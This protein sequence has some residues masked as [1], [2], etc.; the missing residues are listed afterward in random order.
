MKKASHMEQLNRITLLESI[1]RS[2]QRL[3]DSLSTE[4]KE[5]FIQRVR[6]ERRKKKGVKTS[7]GLLPFG[8]T[9][10]ELRIFKG[11]PEPQKSKEFQY[12]KK[13]YE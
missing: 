6:D 1:S 13:K 11:L 3:Y 10:K 5:R 7:L 9:E 12:L 8:V 2:D 4:G